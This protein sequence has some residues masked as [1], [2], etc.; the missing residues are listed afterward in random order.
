MEAA[1]F[2]SPNND[3]SKQPEHPKVKGDDDDEPPPMAAWATPSLRQ[4]NP[5]IFAAYD[6]DRVNHQMRIHVMQIEEAKMA[7]LKCCPQQTHPMEGL[8]TPVYA[9]AD[10]NRDLAWILVGLMV[11]FAWFAWLL[12]RPL[13]AI[14]SL[15]M[16]SGV[17]YA[18]W[19][20]LHS[21]NNEQQREEERIPPHLLDLGLMDAEK[22][23]YLVDQMSASQK[24]KQAK[25]QIVPNDQEDATEEE[26]DDEDIP[27]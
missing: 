26:E 22:V 5:E 4:Y 23:Q 24:R 19:T 6:R 25:K 11:F 14:V 12:L 2:L 18:F 13:Q 20:A 27:C 17:G 8:G 15:L 7:S 16:G 21:T 9:H 1:P 3:N 10:A